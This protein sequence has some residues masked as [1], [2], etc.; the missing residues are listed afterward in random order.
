MVFNFKRIFEL[1]DLATK[2]Q[3]IFKEREFGGIIDTSH[4]LTTKQ[5]EDNADDNPYNDTLLRGSIPYLLIESH[6]TSRSWL[7]KEVKEF[8]QRVGAKR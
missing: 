1:A 4:K 3:N 6:S 8:L 5:L 7:Y 2:L